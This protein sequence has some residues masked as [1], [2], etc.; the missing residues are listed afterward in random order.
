MGREGTVASAA[1]ARRMARGKVLA[2]AAPLWPWPG[3]VG[4]RKPQSRKRRPR[5]AG[6]LQQQRPR[7][8]RGPG[9]GPSLCTLF[10][11][12]PQLPVPLPPP[13]SSPLPPPLSGI[14][15]STSPG[16]N[17][18]NSVALPALNFHQEKIP[19]KT[20]QINKLLTAHLTFFQNPESDP[21][22]GPSDPPPKCP[23][24]APT[25]VA[26]AAPPGRAP[27]SHVSAPAP[28]APARNRLFGFFCPRTK[29]LAGV[30]GSHGKGR[31]SFQRRPAGLLLAARAPE[32]SFL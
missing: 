14:H 4:K 12:L 31:L 9:R 29:G 18:R 7:V 30:P 5:W 15:P 3:L 10:P 25:P 20:K 13:L 27:C 17:F 1:G 24:S 11:H 2:P 26:S 23:G 28:A 21:L 8:T 22:P 6:P 16:T 32:R 19:T